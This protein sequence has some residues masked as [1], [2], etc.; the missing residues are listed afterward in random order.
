MPHPH[1]TVETSPASGIKA[2]MAAG[3][4]L[5]RLQAE[6]AVNRSAWARAIPLLP[7]P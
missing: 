5:D 1:L 4:L 2:V 3:G 6:R 7:G